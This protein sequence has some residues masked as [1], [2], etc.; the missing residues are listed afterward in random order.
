MTTTLNSLTKTKITL[1][2]KFY[3]DEAIRN[4]LPDPKTGEIKSTNDDIATHVANAFRSWSKRMGLSTTDANVIMNVLGTLEK[5]V[6]ADES[7]LDNVPIDSAMK[8]KI[9]EF[10]GGREDIMASSSLRPSASDG[11][12][13]L[14]LDSEYNHMDGTNDEHTQYEQHSQRA[15]HS[16]HSQHAQHAQYVHRSQSAQDPQFAQHF[17]QAQDPLYTQH[18]QQA[19]DPRYI[20]HSQH[21]Q[22]P[23][24]IQHSQD[25]QNVQYIGPQGNIG[26]SFDDNNSTN[27]YSNRNWNMDGNIYQSMEPQRSSQGDEDNN[28]QFAKRHKSFSSQRSINMFSQYNA[29]NSNSS[30]QDRRQPSSYLSSRPYHDDHTTRHTTRAMSHNSNPNSLGSGYHY[31]TNSM[32]SSQYSNPINPRRTITQRTIR[33]DNYTSNLGTMQ[34]LDN[35]RNQFDSSDQ[36]TYSNNLQQSHDEWNHDTNG[37]FNNHNYY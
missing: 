10:F 26:F 4:F 33:R 22:D 15:Q 13:V 9:L 20:Q 12:E 29:N 1:K 2:E 37:Y 16:Q 36:Y 34:P 19:Q 3:Q 25:D 14:L 35:H 21:I 23:Q 31:N 11:R 8:C 6:T 30:N 7:V 17:Q 28:N 24:Y 18:S 32:V 5:I 27:T